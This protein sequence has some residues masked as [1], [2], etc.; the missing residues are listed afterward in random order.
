MKISALY[1]SRIMLHIVITADISGASEFG[2]NLKKGGK[3]D[4]TT[5]TY[6]VSGETIHG[7]TE[8]RGEGASTKSVSGALPNEDGTITM[9]IYVDRSLV[10]AFFNAYKS[11]SS[12]A[13]TE[14]PD[15]QGID[16]FADGDVIIESLHVAVMGSIFD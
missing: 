15:S 13:Y 6:D 12:R 8:N 7:S 10:E 16:L 11:I 3:W 4:C 14:D 2:I 1:R 9:D 5:Y